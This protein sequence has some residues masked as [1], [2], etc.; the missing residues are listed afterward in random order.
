M[1]GSEIISA[2]LVFRSAHEGMS[3]SEVRARLRE[4]RGFRQEIASLYEAVYHNKLN[5]SCGDCYLDAYAV[6]MR[7][8]IKDME[9]HSTRQFELLAGALLR[10]TVNGRKE[11]NTS[12]HNLTDERALYHLATNPSCITLF[13][14]YPKDWRERALAAF[15]P[16]GSKAVR[17]PVCEAQEAS[18]S[19]EKENPQ[20]KASRPAKRTRKPKASAKA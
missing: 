13:S 19:V 4:D 12:H 6:L 2:V 17:K 16:D 18:A 5:L 10:D 20:P 7:D 8:N 11:M 9:E 3:G 1:T 15:N 14:V